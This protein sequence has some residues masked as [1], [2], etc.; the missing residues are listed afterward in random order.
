MKRTKK[1]MIVILTGWGVL[2]GSGCWAMSSNNYQIVQD[3]INFGGT[4]NAASDNYKIDDTMGETATGLINSE[5]YWA[6]IGY[7]EMLE[8][9]PSIAF[10]LS[11]NT[12]SLGVL[13]GMVVNSDR[14]SFTVTV[15]GNG[16]YSVK[17]Y[18]DGSLRTS[19]NEIDDVGDGEVTAG[20]EEYGIRTS[21]DNGQCNSTDKAIENGLVLASSER[22]VTDKT[23]EVIYKVAISPNTLAGDYSQRVYYTV[24]G[25]F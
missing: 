11:K 14:H 22:P 1:N 4:D 17:I 3:S 9:E 7:R 13:N 19:G 23:T 18:K 25:I 6:G 24:A 21:G 15:S 8:S 5:N 12:I 20:Q 2:I 16:G 10:S